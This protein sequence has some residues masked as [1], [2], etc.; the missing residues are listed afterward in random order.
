MNIMEALEGLAGYITLLHTMDILE[1]D[2]MNDLF[3]IE[4]AIN[5][6]VDKT[7]KD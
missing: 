3:A 6:F 2:E 7:L 4:D 5:D 1:K